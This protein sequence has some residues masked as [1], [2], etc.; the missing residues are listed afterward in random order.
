MVYLSRHEKSRYDDNLSSKHIKL[1][2][3]SFI[4]SYYQVQIDSNTFMDFVFI[5]FVIPYI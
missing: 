4:I 5:N 2:S 3:S 1:L